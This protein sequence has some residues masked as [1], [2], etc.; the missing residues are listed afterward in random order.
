METGSKKL[1]FWGLQEPKKAQG[2]PGAR[3]GQFAKENVI[4]KQHFGD[5]L[6]K[7]GFQVPDLVPEPQGTSGSPW[8]PQELP[9]R[10]QGNPREA[11]GQALRNHRAGSL[12]GYKSNTNGDKTRPP[13]RSGLSSRQFC[14]FEKGTTRKMGQFYNSEKAENRIARQFYISDKGHPR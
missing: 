6:P 8:E 4:E 5:R 3:N 1:G 13:G 7:L 14:N 11:P 2:A 9:R 10:P 12:L